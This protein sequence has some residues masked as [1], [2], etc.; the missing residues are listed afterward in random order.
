VKRKRIGYLEIIG[1]GGDLDPEFDS[2]SPFNFPEM[3]R[4]K[5]SHGRA[6]VHF[7]RRR[8]KI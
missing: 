6:G 8:R 4:A 3:R 1:L 2:Q 7:V 5:P